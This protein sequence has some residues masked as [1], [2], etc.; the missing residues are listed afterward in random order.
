[1]SYTFIV[2]RIPLNTPNSR[3]P[4]TKMTAETIT[5]HNTANPTSTARNER[6]WLTNPSNTRTASY[7]YVV[8]SEHVIECI[9]QT[10]VA[11]HA[12][13]S[14][15]NRT[16]IGVEICESGDYAKTLENATKFVAVLLDARGWGVERLRRHFDWS[17]K[18]CPRKM[19]N[20]GVWSGWHA[21]KTAVQIELERLKGS[22]K[23]NPDDAN[24][25]IQTWIGP[26]WNFSQSEE[27]K[28][29]LNRLA[30][31]LRKASDQ[32]TV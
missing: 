4:G 30:N 28:R 18:N 1:M 5:I 22:Y 21:F 14:V 17:G 26:A 16:S 24:T 11:Y 32:P 15:G 29:E 19:N 6:G 31:E 2:D 27:D 3:R 10:E 23:M 25:I 13:H 9:P 12:G 20:D 7:H 8:D